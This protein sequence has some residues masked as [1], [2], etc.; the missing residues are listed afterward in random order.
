MFYM[1]FTELLP[2]AFEDVSRPVA[3]SALGVATL[4]MLGFQALIG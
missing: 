2:E 4:A 1:V 3:L